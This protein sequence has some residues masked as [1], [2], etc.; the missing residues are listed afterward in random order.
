MEAAKRGLALDSDRSSLGRSDGGPN[1]L[2]PPR[3]QVAHEPHVYHKLMTARAPVHRGDQSAAGGVS[4]GGGGAG[5]RQLAVFE[6]LAEHFQRLALGLRRLVQEEDAVVG[7]APFARLG[8]RAA[9]DPPRIGGGVM[10]RA[11]GGSGDEGGVGGGAGTPGGGA[12]WGLV[13]LAP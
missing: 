9:A 8:D 3:T 4:E 2:F 6:R 12:A 11:E 13:A 5:D 1:G 7:Q 10:R